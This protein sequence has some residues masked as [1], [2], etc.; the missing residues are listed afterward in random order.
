MNEFGKFLLKL[1]GK[2]SLRDVHKATGISHTYLST[3]EKGYDPRT[4]KERKPSYEVL[5]KISD[6]Y[7]VDYFELL[8]RAGYIDPSV[9]VDD[10]KEMKINNALKEVSKV[11]KKKVK[12]YDTIKESDLLT[13]LNENDDLHVRGYFLGIEDRQKIANLLTK[14][15]NEKIEEENKENEP[16][17]IDMDKV[18]IAGNERM[19]DLIERSTKKGDK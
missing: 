2:R 8:V 11:A 6:Y 1:R 4:K 7:A 13:I 12:K 10:V 5:Q 17:I 14:I 16:I 19:K 15:V 3:L 9:L 18:K